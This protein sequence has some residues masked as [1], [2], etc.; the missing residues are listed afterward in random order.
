MGVSL[1]PRRAAT[2]ISVMA[3]ERVQSRKSIPVSLSLDYNDSSFPSILFGPIYFSRLKYVLIFII[4][5]NSLKTRYVSVEDSE[6]TC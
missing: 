5:E 2:F 3:I 6:S 4:K 1:P